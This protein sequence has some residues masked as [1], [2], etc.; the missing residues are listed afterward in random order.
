MGTGDARTREN[1][2]EGRHQTVPGRHTLKR[3]GGLVRLVVGTV[4]LMVVLSACVDTEIR[5]ELDEVKSQVS[6]LQTR[7]IEQRD[8]IIGLQSRIEFLETRIASITPTA[9]PFGAP[10]LTEQ[11]EEVSATV[12]SL[13]GRVGEMSATVRALEGRTEALKVCVNTYIGAVVLSEYGGKL[14]PTYC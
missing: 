3:V 12:R 5:S 2:D 13:E 8:Y 1:G 6:T 9:T 4:L 14:I 10:P 11:V 7:R